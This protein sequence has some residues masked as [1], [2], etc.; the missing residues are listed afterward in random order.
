MCV[1]ERGIVRQR[2]MGVRK[3]ERK[4]KGETEEE[5][6]ER[7]RERGKGMRQMAGS[8]SFRLAALPSLLKNKINIREFYIYIK[9]KGQ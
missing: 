3:R 6:E 4:R 9:M 7:E 5:E 8:S 1:R 2:R